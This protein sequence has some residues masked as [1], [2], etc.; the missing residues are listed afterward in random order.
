[1]QWKLLSTHWVKTCSRFIFTFSIVFEIAGPKLNSKNNKNT[2]NNVSNVLPICDSNFAEFYTM[3]MILKPHSSLI[4]S[5][6]PACVF[7]LMC[8]C[9]YCCILQF[10]LPGY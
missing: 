8:V 10:S 7:A 9:V 2:T 4:G 5:Y 3:G 6:I 1:M